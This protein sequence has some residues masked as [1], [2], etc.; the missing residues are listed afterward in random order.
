VASLAE[1]KTFD[2]GYFLRTI[3]RHKVA[4]LVLASLLDYPLPDALHRRLQR[5]AT[6]EVSSVLHDNRVF[7]AEQARIAGSLRKNGIDCILLKGLSLDFSGVRYMGDIDLMVPEEK[8]MES[9]ESVL[10]LD[11]YEYRPVGRDGNPAHAVCTESLPSFEKKRVLRQLP[12]N[13]EFQLIHPEQGVMVE[14]H[15]R[16]IQ[17]RNPWNRYSEIPRP[18]LDNTRMFWERRQFSPELDCSVLAPEHSL[19]LMCPKNAI[20]H[21]P[22]NDTFRLSVLVDLDNLV[23]R[24]IEWDSAQRDSVQLGAAP[25]VLFSLS[26]A[27]ELVGAPIPR[28]VLEEL[29]EQATP[30]QVRAMRIHR[31]CVNS[32]AASSILYSK[33]YQS[34]SPSVFGGSLGQRMYWRLFVPFWLPPRRKI[35]ARYNLAPESRWIVLAYA[36]NP[37]RWIYKTVSKLVQR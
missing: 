18:V 9:I 13:N 36:I 20:K 29:K 27:K 16:L 24:G 7:R 31:K 23:R 3:R 33:L 34:V 17:S 25:F 15:H 26:L 30:A 19:I 32:L 8:L 11:G 22:A 6:S 10:S 1:Q 28:R 35:A 21:A 12:W 37:L 2:W 14:L 4:A 5:L